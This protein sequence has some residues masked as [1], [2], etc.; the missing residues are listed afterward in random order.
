MDLPLTDGYIEAETTSGE[1]VSLDDLKLLEPS[2][3]KSNVDGVQAADNLRRNSGELGMD[4]TIFLKFFLNPSIS[5]VIISVTFGLMSVVA[6][7]LHKLI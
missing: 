6:L 5:G 4:S 2:S 3:D 7:G 1:P